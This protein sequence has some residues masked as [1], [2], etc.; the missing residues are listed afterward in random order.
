M[1]DHGAPL[2]DVEGRL[3]F[4]AQDDT[5]YALGAG[6]ELLWSYL[7]RGDVDAPL[8]LGPGGVLYAGAEDGRLYAIQGAALPAPTR[9]G[10]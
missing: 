1:G 3:Y 9:N 7:T 10:L 8:V 5:I 6:G 4:G 2:E